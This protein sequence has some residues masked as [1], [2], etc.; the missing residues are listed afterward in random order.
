VFFPGPSGSVAGSMVCAGVDGA[1]KRRALI[2]TDDFFSMAAI[3]L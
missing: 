3:S 2:R 1:A